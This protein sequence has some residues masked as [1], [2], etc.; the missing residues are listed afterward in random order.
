MP[1]PRQE[2]SIPERQT[3]GVDAVRHPI[4]GYPIEKGYGALSPRDQAWRVHL[5]LISAR[6]GKAAAEEIR[7]KLL[8]ADQFAAAQTGMAAAKEKL[9][10]DGVSPAA[11]QVK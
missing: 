2:L 3:F 4:T 7:K 11:A 10:V 5:P 1:D 8:D 9:V 6:E